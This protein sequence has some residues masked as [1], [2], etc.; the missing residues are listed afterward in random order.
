MT[1]RPKSCM[2]RAQ[3]TGPAAAV[4]AIAAAVC[5]SCTPIQGHTDTG[6]HRY[7][8]TPIKGHSDTGALR[9]RALLLRSADQ[10]PQRSP[11][12][13]T[14]CPRAARSLRQT[15]AQT[16]VVPRRGLPGSA[17]LPPPS[18]SQG[19][20]KSAARY[21]CVLGERGDID[22]G[23]R[24]GNAAWMPPISEFSQLWPARAA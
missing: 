16:G 18:A 2:Q 12:R 1:L 9:C 22:G 7:R 15:A 3:G 8:G 21:L 23:E 11:I 20:R 19:G 24:Q 4:E 13:P 14:Q 17:S 5:L 10:G 6:A